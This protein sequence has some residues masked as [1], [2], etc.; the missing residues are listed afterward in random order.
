[1][2]GYSGNVNC[3]DSNYNHVLRHLIC[4]KLFAKRKHCRQIG[5]VTRSKVRRAS[6]INTIEYVHSARFCTGDYRVDD[7]QAIVSPDCVEETQTRGTKFHNVH[8]FRRQSV[9]EVPDN[10][11]A[12]SV[13][14]TNV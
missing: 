3:L 1:M 4:C 14:G 6:H 2:C 5:I 11:E 9:L 12:Y 10:V 7:Y 8:V 13:I